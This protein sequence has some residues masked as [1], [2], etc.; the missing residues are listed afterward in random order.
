MDELEETRCPTY[1]GDYINDNEHGEG[2]YDWG[3]YRE[4]YTGQWKNGDPHGKG[5]L[6]KDNGRD[7]IGI[8]KNGNFC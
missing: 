2:V 1:I 3:T 4:C 6:L 7:Q 8:F 5:K